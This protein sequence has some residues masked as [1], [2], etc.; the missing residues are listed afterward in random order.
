M[1]PIGFSLYVLVQVLEHHNGGVDHRADRDRDAAE[2]HDVAVDAEQS[3]HRERDED[4][5]R[6][7]R[8]RDQGAP[9]M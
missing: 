6:Q 7:R 2:T 3:C 9:C 5:Q 8:H 1:R 4:A